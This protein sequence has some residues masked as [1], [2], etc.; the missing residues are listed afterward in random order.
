MC[1]M[2]PRGPRGVGEKGGAVAKAEEKEKGAFFYL[3]AGQRGK[4]KAR[5]GSK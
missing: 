5:R 3:G 4:D 2:D 1:S